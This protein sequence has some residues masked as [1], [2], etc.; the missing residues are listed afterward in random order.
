MVDLKSF[1]EDHGFVGVKTYINSGN[2]IFKGVDVDVEMLKTELSSHFGFPIMLMV[3]KKSSFMRIANSVP[4]AWQNNKEQKTDI[5]FLRSNFDSKA[6]I[7]VL[8]PISGVDEV[9]Y[10]PGALLWNIDR[11]KQGK[12]RMQKGFIGSDLYKSMTARNVNTVRKLASMLEE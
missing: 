9:V 5:L 3:Y 7:E 4:D 11:S 2:V 10:V 6:A 12:S 1:F 8:D